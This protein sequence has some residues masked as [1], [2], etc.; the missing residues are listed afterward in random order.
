MRTALLVCAL[1]LGF[2]N[3]GSAQEVYNLVL[4]NATKMVNTPTTNF[5]QTRISQFKRTSLVY[6]KRKAIETMPTVTEE[7]LNTQAYYL[8]EFL[9]LF[10]DEILKDHKLSEDVRKEKILMFMEVS[11]TNPLFNDTD[12]ETV[13]SY[14][15]EGSELTPFSLD[16][17]WEKAYN[18]AKEKL[19]EK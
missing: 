2:C 7:F 9:S 5:T 17:D 11:I 8:S 16:T 12:Y 18:Q 10:F 1:L 4:E 3:H 6:M 15:N 14:I 19:K 13:H